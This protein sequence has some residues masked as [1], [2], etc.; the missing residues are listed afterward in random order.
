M[1][2]RDISN[3]KPT[4]NEVVTFVRK[5]DSI[6]KSISKSITAPTADEATKD[7][8]NNYYTPLLTIVNKELGRTN[9]D[10]DAYF[11]VDKL[12]NFY[13]FGAKSTDEKGFFCFSDL[14][15]ALRKQSSSYDGKF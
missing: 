6:P 1:L 8:Y 15:E 10:N 7:F 2:K 9:I 12:G 13:E 14:S 4:N 3:P 11:K 5:I